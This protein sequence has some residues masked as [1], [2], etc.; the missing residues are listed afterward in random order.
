MLAAPCLVRVF[1][2][3]F[4]AVFARAAGFLADFFFAMMIPFQDVVECD[5]IPSA[6]ILKREAPAVE[7]RR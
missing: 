1:A 6:G 7:S 2:F 4:D 5:V 3:D